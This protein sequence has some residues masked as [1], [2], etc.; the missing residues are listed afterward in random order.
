MLI[1]NEN[2]L[3]SQEDKNKK[4]PIQLIKPFKQIKDYKFKSKISKQPERVK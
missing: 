2:S 1:K 3:G 4:E